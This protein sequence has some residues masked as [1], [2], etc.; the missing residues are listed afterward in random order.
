MLYIPYVLFFR[1]IPFFV[2]ET[3][4]FIITSACIVFL[5]SCFLYFMLSTVNM[6]IHVINTL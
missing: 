5:F 4:K 3:F 6:Y 2:Q 1:P